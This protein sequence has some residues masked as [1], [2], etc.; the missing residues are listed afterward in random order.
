MTNGGQLNM[1][2]ESRSDI[3]LLGIILVIISSEQ[4]NKAGNIEKH[5]LH[6]SYKHYTRKFC[7]RKH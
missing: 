5:G 6:V 3:M 1:K 7:P 4:Q 2:P